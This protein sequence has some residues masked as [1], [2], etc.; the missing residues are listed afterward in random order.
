MKHS[1]SKEHHSQAL[2]LIFKYG[3][4]AD[5]RWRIS[6]FILMDAVFGEPKTV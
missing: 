5:V 2:F 4:A 6:I 1:T 3:I